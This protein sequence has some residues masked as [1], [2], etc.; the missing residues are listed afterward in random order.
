MRREVENR[1]HRVMITLDDKKLNCPK[2]RT[3]VKATNC[4]R[5]NIYYKKCTYYKQ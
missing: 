5:C 4:D 2:A 1:L 3:C